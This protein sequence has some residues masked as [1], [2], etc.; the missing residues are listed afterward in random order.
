MTVE[1]ELTGKT[2][3]KAFKIEGEFKPGDEKTFETSYTVTEADL[4]KTVVN[5]ATATGKTPDPKKPEPGVTPGE[6]EDPTDPKKPAMSIEKKVIDQ[7]EKYEIGEIVK[8]EITVTN[9]GN[10]TQNNILVE[11]IRYTC[12][13]QGSNNYCR[14]HSCESRPW[15]YNY[16][17]SSCQR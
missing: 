10:T 15:K 9:T 6:T 7:K 13:W 11:D 17:R 4:G 5:V 1:D 16:K 3:D 14:V 12:T 8:Y 2:G